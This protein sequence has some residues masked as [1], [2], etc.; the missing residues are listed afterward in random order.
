MKALICPI[1]ESGSSN[2][3]T[4]LEERCAF[5]DE[6]KHQCCIKTYCLK[7]NNITVTIDRNPAMEGG[8]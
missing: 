7:P 5:W 8:W 3:Y 1:R 4:C 6:D 2:S